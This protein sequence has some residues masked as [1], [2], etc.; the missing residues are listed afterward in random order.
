MHSV[1]PASAQLPEGQGGQGVDLMAQKLEVSIGQRVQLPL[2]GRVL[3]D[4]D[5]QTRHAFAFE[6]EYVPEGQI[7]QVDI[8]DV[9]E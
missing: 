1:L 9:L 2:F 8:P 6:P 7:S 3:K 4:P 5:G